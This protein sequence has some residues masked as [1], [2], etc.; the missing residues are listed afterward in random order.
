MLTDF[1]RTPQINKG[2]GRDHFPGV[3]S[4][5]F[6][7][8][9]I[10]G[11]Q[12]YGKSNPIGFEPAELACGP[13]D[14]HATIFHALGIDPDHMIYDAA[15]RRQ[16]IL[17]WRAAPGEPIRRWLFQI[18]VKGQWHSQVLPASQLAGV[19]R[20]GT[21]LPEYIALTAIDRGG[22]ASPPT[23]LGRR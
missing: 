18:R 17:T 2:A 13:P 10:R 9:G 7:G 23:V 20:A 22:N 6:A 14:L 1:G 5:V 12:V 19:V 21:G 15:A 8:G 11:G 4:A 16:I 3:Y